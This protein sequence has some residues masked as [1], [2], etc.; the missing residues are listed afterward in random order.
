MQSI[1][2]KGRKWLYFFAVLLSA[3]TTFKYAMLLLDYTQERKWHFQYMYL[4]STYVYLKDIPNSGVGINGAT[5]DLV[6]LCVFAGVMFFL[7]KAA[8]HFNQKYETLKHQGKI[9]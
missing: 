7:H 6:L 5:E 9:A 1:Q 2:R 3:V 4:R 8:M